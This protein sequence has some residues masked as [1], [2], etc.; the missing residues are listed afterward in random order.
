MIQEKHIYL[1]ETN[2]GII[3]SRPLTKEESEDN[4]IIDFE[5]SAQYGWEELD[6]KLDE[7]SIKVLGIYNGI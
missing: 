4:D 6:Y 7:D 3:K 2:L 1:I 5:I